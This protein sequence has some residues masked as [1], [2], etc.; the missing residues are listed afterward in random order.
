M[1]SILPIVSFILGV[2]FMII[3]MV[4]YFA[5]DIKAVIFTLIIAVIFFAVACGNVIKGNPNN[6]NEKI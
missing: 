5:A 6:K 4:A 1:K 3:S 2:L